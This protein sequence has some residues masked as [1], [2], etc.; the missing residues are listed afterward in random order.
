MMK[1]YVG[2]LEAGVSGL[3]LRAA[4]GVYGEVT[5]AKVSTDYSTGVS[6]GFGFVEMTVRG[7]GMAAITR[8]DGKKLRW[9]VMLVQEGRSS[10]RLRQKQISKQSPSGAESSGERQQSNATAKPGQGKNK[11]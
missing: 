5:S 2:N 11:Q 3:D 7:H 10:Q 4:F 8:L 1:I 6:R 9:R